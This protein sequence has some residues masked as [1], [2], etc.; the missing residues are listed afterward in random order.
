M[1]DKSDTRGAR[2]C[3]EELEGRRKTVIMVLVF[4]AVNITGSPV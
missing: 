4:I 1:D 2:L 3:S